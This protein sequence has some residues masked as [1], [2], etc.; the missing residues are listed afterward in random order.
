VC[1]KL[2]TIASN[3]FGAPICS[4]CL[5]KK[6]KEKCFKCGKNNIVVRRIDGRP[7]C[8]SCNRR[9]N[10]KNCFNCGKKRQGSHHDDK[11]YCSNCRVKL[12]T[13]K[14]ICV[15]CN[16][17]CLVAYRTFNNMPLC[18][19]CRRKQI[20]EKCSVCGELKQVHT[21]RS[22]K[23]LCCTCYSRTK[24]EY[25]FEQYKKRAFKKK[26]LFEIDLKQ[27]KNIISNPCFY[28]GDTKFIRGVD[29]KNNGQGY[30]LNNC[31][32]SCWKCNKMKG[33]MDF[34]EFIEQI[35]KIFYKVK[36]EK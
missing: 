7:M 13:K 16:K 34:E 3:E 20:I 23:V 9:N 35:D 12:F 10:M 21:R 1:G 31:V 24:I 11:F 22:G 19:V 26:L 8:G 29:R 33:T 15:E 17:L 30:I 18:G 2:S 27:F 32:S 5:A 28:C 4:A 36:N 6:K 14:E 25:R